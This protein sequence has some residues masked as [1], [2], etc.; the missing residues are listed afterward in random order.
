QQSK[1]ERA[2]DGARA[3]NY[4]EPRAPG[5]PAADPGRAGGTRRS[6]HRDQGSDGQPDPAQG[7]GADKARLDR[8]H[9]PEQ[10]SATDPVVTDL[11]AG[12]LS[13]HLDAVSYD[14]A[15]ISADRMTKEFSRRRTRKKGLHAEAFLHSVAKRL[16]RFAGVFLR[17]CLQAARAFEHLLL[18]ADQ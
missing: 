12:D 9:Q 11:T 16:R 4:G 3:A 14:P 18:V 1:R 6:G 15:E 17:G 8:G 2:G 7:G 10:G 5:G 13:Y